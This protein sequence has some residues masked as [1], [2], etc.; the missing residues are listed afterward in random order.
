MKRLFAQS[1]C[2]TTSWTRLV[3]LLILTLIMAAC[4][5]GSLTTQSSQPKTTRTNSSPTQTGTT[6]SSSPLKVKVTEVRGSNGGKDHY[7]F[8][9]NILT[10]NVGNI[11]TFV[12]E[13]DA[14]HTLIST[15]TGGITG[16]SNLAVNETQAVQFLKPG[17][18]T[19]S[20]QE[21]PD[22]KLSATVG[23]SASDIIPPQKIEL[24]EMHGTKVSYFF[25]PTNVGVDVGYGILIVNQTNET[26]ILMITPA[27]GVVVESI[28]DKNETQLLQFSAEYNYT[29]TIKDH[30][31]GTMVV[32]SD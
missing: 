29:I 5:Q 24:S 12:N 32:I 17:S 13:S 15:L 4:G 18:F 30:P 7:F 25:N 10:G 22:A 16:G 8:S 28:I 1:L 9:P 23:G 27:D 2:R 20:S 6:V 26:Q 31:E 3:C 19:I 21:H 11:L 14:I